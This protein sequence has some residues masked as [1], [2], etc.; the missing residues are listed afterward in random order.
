MVFVG[1][2]NV[3][4]GSVV[5]LVCQYKVIPKDTGGRTDGST[6]FWGEMVF[7]AGGVTM[8]HGRRGG[9]YNV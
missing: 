2:D 1:K 5:R 9:H 6:I 3:I 4:L 7:R 8:K